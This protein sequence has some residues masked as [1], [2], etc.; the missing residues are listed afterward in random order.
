MFSFARPATTPGPQHLLHTLTLD[1]SKRTCH[2]LRAGGLAVLRGSSAVLVDSTVADCTA[3][4]SF[5]GGLLAL[6]ANV[7]LEGGSRIERCYAQML[8]GAMLADKCNVALLNG[9]VIS[10]SY[11]DL[12]AGGLHISSGCTQLT[13]PRP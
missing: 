5:G 10:E 3:T 1:P 6:E 2:V 4:N 12:Q 8:G 9:S 13:P 7:T 11:A